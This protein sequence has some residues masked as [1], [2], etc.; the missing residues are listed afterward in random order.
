VIFGSAGGSPARFV[1]ILN[2]SRTSRPRSLQPLDAGKKN[3]SLRKIIPRETVWDGRLFLLAGGL[4]FR[5]GFFSNGFFSFSG[6][7][8]LVFFVNRVNAPTE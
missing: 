3:P 2:N 1:S 6:H 5:S 4:F 8:V 7:N